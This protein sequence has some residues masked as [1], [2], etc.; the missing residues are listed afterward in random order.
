MALVRCRE[1]GREVST[2]AT[3]CPHCGVP[4]PAPGPDSPLAPRSAATGGGPGARDY[5]GTSL[6]TGERIVYSTRLHWI[7]LLP[8]FVLMVV[9]LVLAAIGFGYSTAA[10]VAL[11]AVA[12]AIG[13]WLYLTYVSSEFAVT[14]ARVVIKTGWLSRRSV[15]VLVAKV[16]SI[17]VAQSV[18]GRLLGY[19][20]ITITGSGGTREQ[21]SRIASPLEF[22][23]HVQ[24]QVLARPDR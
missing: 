19:G 1:C 15:E 12:I 4:D 14:T 16:E 18:M 10:G 8:G 11:L 9:A 21:F 23:E 22:R 13:G 20:D 24:A 7:G 2:E 6:T 5:V 3:A 17:G